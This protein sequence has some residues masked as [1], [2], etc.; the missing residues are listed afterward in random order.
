MLL[1]DREKI[2]SRFQKQ[3]EAVE[4][5]KAAEPVY[6]EQRLPSVNELVEAF[7]PLVETLDE[8]F[9]LSQLYEIANKKDMPHPHLSIQRLQEANVLVAQGD[10]TFTWSKL[11]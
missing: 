1:D 7:S 9:E 11:K 10:G 5:Q 3:P 2:I 6:S 4:P 8:P